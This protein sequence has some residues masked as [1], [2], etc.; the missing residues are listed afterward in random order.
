MGKEFDF[1]S[2]LLKHN[3]HR[4]GMCKFRNKPETGCVVECDTF[5]QCYRCGWN[6]LVESQRKKTI[7]EEL[8]KRK[9]QTEE[10]QKWLIGS[11]EFP[12]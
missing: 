6:P 4:N 7:R 5:S 9:R 3:K 1:V 11:G 12:H 10:P 2:A 8:A